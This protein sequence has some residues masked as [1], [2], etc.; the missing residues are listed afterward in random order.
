MSP[1]ILEPKI[2]TLPS[3]IKKDNIYTLEVGGPQNFAILLW[4]KVH[5]ILTEFDILELVSV[6]F[7]FC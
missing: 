4:K 5:I 7:Y 2:F 3:C 6:L 1:D